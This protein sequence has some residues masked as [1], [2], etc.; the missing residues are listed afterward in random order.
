MVQ[1]LGLLH[2][3]VLELLCHSVSLSSMMVLQAIKRA[4]YLEMLLELL[5]KHENCNI[6]HTLIERTYLHLFVN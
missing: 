6:A 5:F 2:Y 3:K 1:K 4:K